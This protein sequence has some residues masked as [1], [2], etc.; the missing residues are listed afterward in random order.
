MSDI[1]EDEISTNKE[2]YNNSATS[3]DDTEGE[4]VILDDGFFSLKVR[5]EKEEPKIIHNENDFQVVR[6][7]EACEYKYTFQGKGEYEYIS[8]S[9][10]GPFF[11]LEYGK[12]LMRNFLNYSNNPYK[13][14]SYDDCYYNLSNNGKYVFI[15]GQTRVELPKSQA[16]DMLL[17]DIKNPKAILQEAP[18]RVEMFD[19]SK[20]THFMA[21]E[22]VNAF[23]LYS[24]SKYVKASKPT[25]TTIPPSIDFLLNHLISDEA[26]KTSL[27]NALAYHLKT[28]KAIHLGWIFVGVEGAGKGTIM[29]VIEK[30]FGMQNFQKS[31]LTSFTGDKIKG[32][33]NKLICYV[34]ES[35]DHTKMYEVAENL[36]AIIGNEQ[37]A[38]R[39]L[40]FDE[41]TAKNHAMFFFTVNSFGFKLSAKDR[42]FNIIECKT[43]LNR[44]VESTDTFYKKIDS[45]LQLFTDYL[46]SYE[47][48]I[49]MTRKVVATSFRV[50]M[51]NNHLPVMERIARVILENSLEPLLES[52]DED[53]H[54]ENIENIERILND[55]H[56][57]GSVTGTVIAS[58]SKNL[59][60]LIDG[61][62]PKYY[63]KNAFTSTIKNKWNYTTKKVNGAAT[64]VYIIDA[65]N[66][67]HYG[68]EEHTTSLM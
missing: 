56:H 22:E 67:R 44:A 17:Y 12:K 45:E 4:H 48:N 25:T 29:H 2:T 63:R 21:A 14:A 62:N 10:S 35:A 50:K 41:T 5:V 68:D 51:I 60:D 3:E 32:A 39:A 27:I 19:P 9:L 31:K 16:M 59:F 47:V 6:H 64:K 13:V 54:L 34:D 36:K 37:Y 66:D 23:N 40:Y 26:T 42:R 28:G 15:K 61:I 18:R 38:S 53:N 11:D 58:L 24:P 43:P 20:K 33:P 30:I 46:L 55:I 49:P 8:F 7:F 65:N 52:I 1:F 57:C